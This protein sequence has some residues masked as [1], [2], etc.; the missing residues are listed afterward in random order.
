MRLRRGA[1]ERLRLEQSATPTPG[2]HPGHVSPGTPADPPSDTIPSVDLVSVHGRSPARTA[3]MSAGGREE[4]RRSP[5]PGRKRRRSL[6]DTVPKDV[7]ISQRTAEG[8]TLSRIRCGLHRV[9]GTEKVAGRHC[10]AEDEARAAL[11]GAGF[12]AAV[13][14]DSRRFL[15]H[16]ARHRSGGVNRC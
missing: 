11:E 7:V 13:R 4:R 5:R 10:H 6:P 12:T 3:A 1:S 15:R 2:G 16:G 9:E 14:H 8:S